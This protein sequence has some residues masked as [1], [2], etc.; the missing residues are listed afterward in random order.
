MHRPVNKKGWSDASRH[1]PLHGVRHPVSARRVVPHTSAGPSSCSRS[2]GHRV[3]SWSASHWCPGAADGRVRSARSVSPPEPPVGTA[4]TPPGP[5]IR[6]GSPLRP[7]LGLSPSDPPRL[8]RP[9]CPR[10]WRPPRRKRRRR[11]GRRRRRAAC[12]AARRQG[13]PRSW[14]HRR[15]G[16]EPGRGD[17]AGRADEPARRRPCTRTA[18]RIARRICRVRPFGPGWNRECACPAFPDSAVSEASWSRFC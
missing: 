9:R 12:S 16:D 4:A 13:R 15:R 17:E 2:G 14:T 11:L 7:L 18:Y 10:A 6:A 1:A 3:C 5:C 8:C